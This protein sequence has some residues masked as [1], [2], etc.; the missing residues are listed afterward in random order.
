MNQ[1]DPS[2]LN[3]DGV[4]S[5]TVSNWVEAPNNESETNKDSTE[6]S[7]V[8]FDLTIK[9]MRSATRRSISLSGL[10]HEWAKKLIA[11]ETRLSLMGFG[12][13]LYVLAHCT[14]IQLTW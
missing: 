10:L 7:I 5:W 11:S 9:D 3:E 14:S 1:F 13:R 6:I 4:R 2:A 8:S 12:G